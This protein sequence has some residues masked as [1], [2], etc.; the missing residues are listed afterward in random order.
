MPPSVPYRKFPFLPFLVI[1]NIGLSGLAMFAFFMILFRK[2]VLMA[3]GPAI[4]AFPGIVLQPWMIVF[5]FMPFGCFLA[6]VFGSL[7]TWAVYGWLDSKGYL[8]RS[9][10]VIHQIPHGRLRF[11]SFGAF[12]FASL[13]FYCGYADLLSINRGVPLRMEYLLGEAKRQVSDGRFYFMSDFIDSEYIWEG[14]IPAQGW[15]SVVTQLEM[16]P[17]ELRNIPEPFAKMPPYWW[18]F[19]LSEGMIAYSTVNFPAGRGGDGLHAFAVWDPRQQILRI[20]FKDNF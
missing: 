20:W 9:S 11:W 5:F 12:V 7:V 2:N 6:P 1:A 19:Q 4:L 3:L 15:D 13:I 18:S 8:E 14:K 16:K 10:K 17:V